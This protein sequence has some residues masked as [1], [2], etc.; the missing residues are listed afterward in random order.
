ME[1]L[2]AADRL[3][4]SLAAVEKLAE[5]VAASEKLAET[6]A[7]VD[8]LAQ[9]VA[10]VQEIAESMAASEQLARDMEAAQKVTEHA[11]AAQKPA[12]HAAAT[13]KLAESVKEAA[14]SAG[15]LKVSGL[16]QLMQS[17]SHSHTGSIL[18]QMGDVLEKLQL[19][20]L[21]P[22]GR[23]S[24]MLPP[25]PE[26]ETVGRLNALISAERATN[27]VLQQSLRQQEQQTRLT[28]IVLLIAGASLAVGLAAL[29]YS[30]LLSG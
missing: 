10:G 11:A 29:T 2:R 16:S 20:P 26:W 6:M 15:D 28:V 25:S 27:R 17:F 21:P 1:E 14:R 24:I 5:D 30:I 12:E 23:T 18:K 9:S 22:V 7:A 19:P 4:E 8:K 3:S 13:Q